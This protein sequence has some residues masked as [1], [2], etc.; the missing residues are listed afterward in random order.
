MH[1]NNDLHTLRQYGRDVQ[2][3]GA[4]ESP[5]KKV[6]LWYRSR[7]VSSL[8]NKMPKE[9]GDGGISAAWHQLDAI[10]TPLSL[11]CHPV[12]EDIPETTLYLSD[13][14]VNRL[15]NDGFGAAL[16]LRTLCLHILKLR[17]H[18]T[19]E[20]TW[21]KDGMGNSSVHVMHD[22]VRVTCKRSI[23]LSQRIL[24]IAQD[25]PMPNAAARAFRR[26]TRTLLLNV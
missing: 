16:G 21:S 17:A 7:L 11:S 2:K 9:E 15:G 23:D 6:L 1:L 20:K 22:D 14:S 24:D 5:H 18:P 4:I 3:Q 10:L 25:I 19:C 8:V 13:T 26:K 12:W